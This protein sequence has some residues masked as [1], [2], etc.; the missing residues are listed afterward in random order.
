MILLRPMSLK[1][2]LVVDKAD[3]LERMDARIEF[4]RIKRSFLRSC[5]LQT[6][7]ETQAATRI[8]Q[9]TVTAIAATAKGSEVQ[10]NLSIVSSGSVGKQEERPSVN[11][12]YKNV[13]LTSTNIVFG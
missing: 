1:P 11:Y 7:Q 10:A 6:Q 8:K 3:L 4:L 2:P 5:D 13:E 9:P 12:T